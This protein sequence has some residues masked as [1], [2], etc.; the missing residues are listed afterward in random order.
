MAELLDAEAVTAAVAA[1]DGWQGDPDA[2]VRTVEL[3]SFPEAIAV[4]DAVAVVAEVLDHHPDIDIRW[5]TVT[6][7][8][9]THS[10]GGVTRRD[11]ELARRID[12]IVGAR[13]AAPPLS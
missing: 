3:A 9:Q 12:G 13:T 7:R 1:L 11:V 4:V 8:C 5:R 2:I 6:F 10:A